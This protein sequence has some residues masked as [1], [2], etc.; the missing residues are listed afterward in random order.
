MF[1]KTLKENLLANSGERDQT[2]RFVASDLVLL[3]LPMSHKKDARLIWVKRTNCLACTE[4]THLIH[5]I[6][7]GKQSKQIKPFRQIHKC[8]TQF[9]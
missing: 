9:D 6:M 2:P 4:A 5:C 8:F 1:T 3:C 7:A